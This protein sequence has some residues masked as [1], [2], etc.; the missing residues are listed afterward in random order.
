M[1]YTDEEKIQHYRYL[2]ATIQFLVNNE[3]ITEDW[4]EEHK[5]KIMGYR[6]EWMDNLKYMNTEIDDTDFRQACEDAEP[7]LSKL[8]NSIIKQGTFDT[9][10]YL[11]FCQKIKFM[12]DFVWEHYPESSLDLLMDQLKI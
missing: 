11:V 1:N 2:V 10:T 3:R 6:R 9:R 7:L 4:M 5:R 8:V 12:V